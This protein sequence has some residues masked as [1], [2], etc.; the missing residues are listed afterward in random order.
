MKRL[1]LILTCVTLLILLFLHKNP[2]PHTYTKPRQNP[3]FEY[4][5]INGKTYEYIH[6]EKIPN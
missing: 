5:E 6:I 3:F 2:P 1:I 4:M